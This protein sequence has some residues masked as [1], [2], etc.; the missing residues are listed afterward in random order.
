MRYLF[1][2]GH[3]AHVHYFKYIIKSLKSEGHEVYVTA[4]D[5]DV[6]LDLLESERISYINRGKGANSTV[7][8]LVY[9][10]WGSL[11]LAVIGKRRRIDVYIGFGSPYAAFA[12]YINFRK[13]V[14]LDDTENAVLGQ[15][16]YK[17]FASVML[18]PDSFAKNFG[19]RHKKFTSFMEL[20]YLHP[21]VFTFDFDLRERE[22]T[23][24][25]RFV[26]WNA[27]HDVGHTGISLDAK[28]R[29]VDS[30]ESNGFQVYISS[31]NTLPDS[32][33]QYALNIEPS[34][35]HQFLSNSSILLGESATMASE[36][37]MLG[38]P[39]FYFDNE[40]RGY[41]NML[42]ERYGLVF[43]FEES[44]DAVDNALLKLN[45]VVRCDIKYWLNQREALLADS[46]N[47]NGFLLEELKIL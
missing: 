28:K 4:R 11:L 43:N 32:L 6:T 20:F 38:V 44:D 1:D 30:L 18:S 39:A 3:P 24:L 7:G 5:K 31:E 41:T 46:I 13:S 27:A 26:G 34:E 33:E 42:E 35:M 29:L 23:A 12:S 10:V 2:L 16:F 22:K 8:K 21:D 17:R 19:D 15:S 14:I 40:G 9:L 25:L 37:A 47:P 45:E 36:A